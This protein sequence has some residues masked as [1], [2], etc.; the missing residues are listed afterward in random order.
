MRNF[1][2]FQFDD[3]DFG[4]ATRH[5][6][7]TIYTNDPTIFQV[8]DC[9]DIKEV[10]VRYMIGYILAAHYIMTAVVKHNAGIESSD[11]RKSPVEEVP[12]YMDYFKNAT[13]SDAQD[14]IHSD[15]NHAW[16][17]IDLHRGTIW[18]H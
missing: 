6:L 15:H 16:C 7:S 18:T 10:V 14:D 12:F 5:A 11:D 17:S 2:T 3:N 9:K 1:I 8:L 4:N 13:V